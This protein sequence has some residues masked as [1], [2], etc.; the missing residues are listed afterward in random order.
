MKLQFLEPFPTGIRWLAN[1]IKQVR[2]VQ[3][4]RKNVIKPKTSDEDYLNYLTKEKIKA[5]RKYNLKGGK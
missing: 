1:Q 5:S 4:T 3:A 2:K